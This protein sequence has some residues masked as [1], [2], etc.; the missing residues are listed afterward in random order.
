MLL[1]WKG[2]STGSS[3]I[4]INGARLVGKSFLAEEFGKRE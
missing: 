1:K 2:E 4:L 3:A